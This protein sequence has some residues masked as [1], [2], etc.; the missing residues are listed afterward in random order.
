MFLRW[1]FHG[2]LAF[3]SKRQLQRP[4]SLVVLDQSNKSES[5]HL[6]PEVAL[7]QSKI[8]LYLNF[9]IRKFNFIILKPFCLATH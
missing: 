9:I 5:V 6:T 7:K 1:K 3:P 2:Q 8:L 4:E